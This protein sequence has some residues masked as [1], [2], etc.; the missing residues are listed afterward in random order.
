MD[1]KAENF[2][3]GRQFRLNYLRSPTTL[4]DSQR[5]RLRIK[6]VVNNIIYWNNYN[7]FA[8]FVERS[9]GVEYAQHSQDK[10]WKSAEIGD[11]LSLV[12]VFLEYHRTETS[13][14]RTYRD[15]RNEIV[16]ELRKTFAEENMRYRLDDSGGVHYLVDEIFEATVSSTLAG[17]GQSK[18]QGAK[19]ALLIGLDS[20]GPKNQSGKQLIRN[21]FEAAESVFLVIANDSSLNRI[22]EAA[23]DKYLKPI[24]LKKYS[25][26]PDS[27][28]K[29]E[30]LLETYKP[31][32]KAAHPYR[33][34]V[35]FE[36]IHE[37]PLDI[38][39][40]MSSQGMAFI[41]YMAQL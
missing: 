33:H 37:A 4:Q 36:A 19:A 7:K 8:S 28:D 34:G 6:S 32:V 20:I 9:L 27:S 25:S 14:S 31:W 41:R 38:A 30:R 11:I 5:K 24:M 12:T 26:V 23:M 18:F 22:N 13:P 2:P 16:L 3:D 15:E 17:L 21:I 1:L 40:S 35:S 10:F 39:I 29:V